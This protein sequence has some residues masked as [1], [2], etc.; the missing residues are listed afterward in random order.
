PRKRVRL[1]VYGETPGFQ[2]APRCCHL[3]HLA[4]DKHGPCAAPHRCLSPPL[5]SL[6]ASLFH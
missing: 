1:S 3:V 2:L 4:L 5:C 6:P